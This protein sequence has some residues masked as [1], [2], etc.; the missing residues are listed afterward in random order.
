M[1]HQS[2]NL[3]G[4]TSELSSLRSLLDD[5]GEGHGQ[6]ALLTGE[7]GIGKTTLAEQLLSD[8][9]GRGYVPARGACFDGQYTPPFWLWTQIVRSLV[10]TDHGSAAFAT[11]APAQRLVINRVVPG[12]DP[13][14]PSADEYS[15]TIDQR[16]RFEFHDSVCRLITRL[17]S[18]NPVMLVLEDLHWADES[19]LKLLEFAAQQLSNYAVF[20][21]GTYRDTDITRDSVLTRTLGQMTR[22][23]SFTRFHIAGLDPNAM[24]RLIRST[25]RRTLDPIV[26]DR[27][28]N[29]AAGNPLFG[30]ELARSLVETQTQEANVRLPEGIAEAVGSRLSGLTRT[31]IDVMRLASVLGTRFQA[32]EL[33]SATSENL[34]VVE[35]ALTACVDL[36]LIE[37]LS[38]APGTYQFTHALIQETLYHELTPTQ[39]VRTHAAIAK[40]LTASA[41]S[42]SD[43]RLAAVARHHREGS[44]LLDL[45]TVNDYVVRAGDHA[46]SRYSYSEAAGHYLW[47]LD[48]I[49][50]TSDS[51]SQASLIERCAIS[52]LQMNAADMQPGWDKLR[53]AVRMY[54]RLGMDDD[55][56][57]LAS[58]PAVVGG[59]TG[60]VGL[61]EE[62]L[63][64]ATPGSKERG[65]L[66][67]R[68]IVSL[69][70]AGRSDESE[71]A[72]KETLAIAEEWGDQPLRARALVHGSQARY[73]A[74]DPQTAATRGLDAI[75]LALQVNEPLSVL[76][77]LDFCVE[78]LCATGRT[79]E[80]IGV[81]GRCANISDE[82]SR[83][84]GHQKRAEGMVA[85]Y[86]GDWER[87]EVLAEAIPEQ[88][89]VNFRNWW[90]VHRSLRLGTPY[91]HL[92]A[93]LVPSISKWTVDGY[94]V[95][96]N[97]L[98]TWAH[99]QPEPELVEL[100]SR[101]NYDDPVIT[102][103]GQ[104]RLQALSIQRDLLNSKTPRPQDRAALEASM[105]RVVP[106]TDVPIDRILGAAA[107]A[108]G[109]FEAARRHFVA[110]IEFCRSAE[111]RP[112]LAWSLFDLLRIA[113]KHPD[114]V[115]T[116]QAESIADEASSICDEIEMPAL[117]ALI[118]E[119]L[120]RIRTTREEGGESITLP[121][122]ISS[123]EAEVLS[124]LAA[125]KSNQ[126]IAD[127][128]FISRY[129]VVRHVSNI[130]QK[131]GATN[132]SEATAYAHRRGLVT[133]T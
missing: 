31:Q 68:Y 36:S 122:G 126:E 90:S 63:A 75:E 133:T 52:M 84:F 19:D 37:E 91:R 10:E 12:L 67:A 53:D 69:A 28:V 49:S 112:S 21:L 6:V 88:F 109:D 55:A 110:A 106:R 114:L 80:A 113:D 14:S 81:L 40:A 85:L 1:H 41:K 125:G 25:A 8:S 5:S 120:E 66:L 102:A 118:I 132:R 34:D 131:I 16:G 76:R 129:T 103:E 33:T 71:E 119:T 20:I 94:H 127:E 60:V 35:A 111:F 15:S 59:I 108:E 43:D 50:D 46:Y 74:N 64:V 73:R 44:L 83:A 65:W 57:R 48:S 22:M 23:Q 96:L 124:L 17:G 86:R 123:R 117:A 58:F 93:S 100:C 92:F 95:A 82:F 61:V 13:D 62:G 105:S 7:P 27:L 3:I 39:L 77:V 128:L 47:A 18:S 104:V 51:P 107:V 32:S 121:D 56:V 70:D 101:A 30:R 87:I 38:T 2:E 72:F 11:L 115:K 45:T 4:R 99:V 98:S 79:R 97:I 42:V 9:L 26:V 130:F 54:I 116:D 24:D 89:R 78:S 29:R